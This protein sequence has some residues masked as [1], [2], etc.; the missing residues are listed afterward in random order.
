MQWLPL[1]KLTSFGDGYI[2]ED[3]FL[4]PYDTNSSK[5]PDFPYQNYNILIRKNSTKGVPGRISFSKKGY[6]YS[7][8][9]DEVACLLY[10]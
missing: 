1:G 9:G 2:S 8:R 6:T 3:E 7:R 10:M 5:N 4:L